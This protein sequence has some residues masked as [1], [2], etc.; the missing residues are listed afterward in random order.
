MRK[1]KK[2]LLNW[3]VILTIVLLIAAAITINYSPNPE[4]VAIRSVATNSSASL[5]GVESPSPAS[6]PRSR[7]RIL[8]INNVPIEDVG[9]YHELIST[10][11][12]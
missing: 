2:I 12:V 1:A 9:M 6:L 11:Q 5:A 8:T 7:E 4:G 10:L 3:R